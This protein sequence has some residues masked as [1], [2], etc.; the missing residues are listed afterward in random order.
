MTRISFHYYHRHGISGIYVNDPKWEDKYS[1]TFT[2]PPKIL[3]VKFV[4]CQSVF[5]NYFP[6]VQVSLLGEIE[7]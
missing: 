6:W 7:N 5:E 3:D 4:V 1:V 2:E